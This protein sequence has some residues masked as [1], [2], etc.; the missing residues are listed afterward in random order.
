MF[1]ASQHASLDPKRGWHRSCVFA[2]TKVY[3]YHPHVEAPEAFVAPTTRF[4][5]ARI[6]RAVQRELFWDPFLAAYD[7]TV[8]VDDGTVTLTGTVDSYA[9]LRS[10][11]ILAFRVGATAVE[12][13]LTVR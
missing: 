13:N 3:H 10:A 1:H 7:I 9:K 6:A 12:N 8:H 5:D 2:A 11:E 4:T